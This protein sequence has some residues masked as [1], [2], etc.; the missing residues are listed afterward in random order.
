MLLTLGPERLQSFEPGQ[1]SGVHPTTLNLERSRAP[2]PQH[3]PPSLSHCN[4][5]APLGWNIAHLIVQPSLGPEHRPP[6]LSTLIDRRVGLRPGRGP[7]YRSTVDDQAGPWPGTP[8][9]RMFNLAHLGT[10]HTHKPHNLPPTHRT[11]QTTHPL[12]HPHG[13]R[14]AC[15]RCA[16][17][18]RLPSDVARNLQEPSPSLLA[19]PFACRACKRG[20]PEQSNPLGNPARARRA[21]P[22]QLSPQS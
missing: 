5:R 3:R 1:G 22:E 2:W 19:A 8:P 16:G 17:K 10:T 21:N 11:L 18:A 9:A 4:D 15:V 12:A 14:V 7:T 6:D 20:H 13:T